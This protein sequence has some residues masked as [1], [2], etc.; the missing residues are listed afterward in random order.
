[1]SDSATPW[2]VAC[3]LQTVALSMGFSRQE[4][5]NRLPF[6]PPGDLPNPGIDLGLLHWQE[7]SLLSEAPRRPQ[8]EPTSAKYRPYMTSHKKHN[9]QWCKSVIFFLRLGTIQG[10]LL[11]PL[12]FSIILLIL[13]T[14]IR[15]EKEKRN[16]DW[17]DGLKFSLMMT[18]YYT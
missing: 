11:T 9:S 4:C 10:C 18:W 17:K 14:S 15:E 16:P 5:W 7:N 8:N 12:L 3:Q 1:M 13:V 2:T 6:P